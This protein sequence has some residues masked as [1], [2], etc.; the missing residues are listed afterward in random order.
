MYF[1][2]VEDLKFRIFSGG[3]CP[4]PYPPS[5]PQKKPLQIVGTSIL[6]LNNKSHKPTSREIYFGKIV[7]IFGIA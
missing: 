7:K 2:Q 4:G 3:A 5:P 6:I 1:Q